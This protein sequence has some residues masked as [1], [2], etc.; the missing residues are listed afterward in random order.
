MHGAGLSTAPGYD[1][2]YR[3]VIVKLSE[4]PTMANL[5]ESRIASIIAAMDSGKTL[6][7]III[8]AEDGV[9]YIHDGRHRV[10]VYRDAGIDT[11]TAR[12]PSVQYKDFVA[13]HGNV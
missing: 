9:I 4:L 3:T 8:Q 2:E 6:P 1:M 12:I 7:P 10:E 5:D 11:V 13:C